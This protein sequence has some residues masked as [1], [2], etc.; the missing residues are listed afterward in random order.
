MKIYNYDCDGALLCNHPRH[1]NVPKTPSR[2][3]ITGPSGSGKTNLVLNLI[4][5]G[6]HWDSLYIF[7][8][9]P[10]ELKYEK[11]RE[12]CE[13]ANEIEPFTYC[14]DTELTISVDD[15]DPSQH[16]LIIFD[17]FISDQSS[18]KSIFDLFIR[19]RKKNATVIFLTQSY[20]KVPKPLR[21]QCSYYIFFNTPDQREVLELYKNH[22]CNLTKDQFIKTFHSSTCGYNFLTLDVQGGKLS[23]NFT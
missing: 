16:H 5:D 3:L 19:S 22:P 15:L 20:F 9:D 14:F 8:K 18:F 1:K 10:S 17:D 13:A 23:K 6:L 7:C 12:V 4:Y 11:L 2:I 21:L